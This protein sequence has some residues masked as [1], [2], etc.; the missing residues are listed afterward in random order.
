MF[1]NL[2]K[3]SLV[4]MMGFVF[5]ASTAT[6]AEA[7]HYARRQHAHRSTY[8]PARERHHRHNPVVVV[9]R[10]R[11][12]TTPV[13]YN[14][15]VVYTQPIVYREPVVYS[16]PVYTQPVVYREPT[17]VYSQPSCGRSVVYSEPVYYSYPRDRF[18][19]DFN[20]GRAG[21][22]SFYGGGIGFDWR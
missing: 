2:M 7:Q 8:V 17:V 13:Y 20:F 10:P 5:V 21:H 11:Y 4:A 12:Y 9:N 22:R 18:S 14:R 1:T 15:P 6:P 19:V 3:S 16:E